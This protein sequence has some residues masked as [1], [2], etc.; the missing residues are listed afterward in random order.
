[1]ERLDSFTASYPT[2]LAH[3]AAFTGLSGATLGYTIFLAVH[4][5]CSLEN[6]DSLFI[7]NSD[8]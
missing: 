2:R 6:A 7:T 4:C 8:K 5:V 1:M 3:N